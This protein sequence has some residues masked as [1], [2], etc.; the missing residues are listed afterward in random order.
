MDYFFVFVEGPDDER[1]INALFDE[2][3]ITVIKYAREKKEHIN[4][5]IKSIKSMPNCDYIV[6]CD[7]DLK[8]LVKKKNEILVQFPACEVEKIIVSIA[9]IESWYI[10]GV[11]ESTS[12]TIKIKYIY[13][14]DSITKE[15]FDQMIPAKMDRINFMIEILKKFNVSEAIPR[16]K[17]L[18]YFFNYL[19]QVWKMTVL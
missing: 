7:V 8:S 16:N 10:A 15:K 2:D 9:E 1:F 13:Y 14:T 6:I 11:D 4:R 5:F 19:T 18:K 17:S 3:K 12:K